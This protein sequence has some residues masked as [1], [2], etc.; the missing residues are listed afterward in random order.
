MITRSASALL[1]FA[2]LAMASCVNQE[3]PAPPAIVGE[4]RS[5]IHFD[6]G[7]LASIHNLEFMLVFNDGGTMTE[8]SN[9]DGA[10][11][12]PPA[13]GIWRSVGPREFEAKYEFYATRAPAALDEITK[14]GGWMPA[15]RG[16][17]FEKITLSPDGKSFTSTIRYEAFGL[18]GKPVEGGGEGKG[19]GSR[20]E[21]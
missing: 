7:A 20:L 10:P 9:Y 16:L 13:Y 15:G 19:S 18:D 8:S 3:V 17:L 1:L 6:S 21:F 4:W 5:S 11:P 14:G 2:A 12:V